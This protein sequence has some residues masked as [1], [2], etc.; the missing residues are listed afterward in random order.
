MLDENSLSHLPRKKVI[1]SR[2]N[3]IGGVSQHTQCNRLAGSSHS[4]TYDMHAA[5]EQLV[6]C[7][8]AVGV[9]GGSSRNPQDTCRATQVDKQGVA[10]NWQSQWSARRFATGAA[11]VA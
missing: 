1:A 2:M 7:R 10:E 3:G 8:V 4:A 9:R 11:A 5:C 6:D